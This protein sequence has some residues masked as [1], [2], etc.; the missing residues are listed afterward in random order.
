MKRL[1]ILIL[2][3]VLLVSTPRQVQ[4]QQLVLDAA[5]LAQNVVQALQTILM[6]ANQVLELTPLDEIILSDSF[7]SDLD[8]LGAIIEA[9][10]GLSYDVSSL[11]AQI[12]ALFD[13]TSAPNNS[14]DLQVRLAEIRRVVF[15]SYVYALRT[16][17]LL[18]TTLSAIRHLK[19]LVGAIGDYLGNMQGN[20]SLSQVESTIAETLSRLQVQS[21]AYERAQSVERLTEALTIE[22]I[23]RMNEQLLFDWPR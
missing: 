2:L 17:T 15:D 16:Q 14:R 13:L 9:A 11:Q 18:R 8:D 21:G 20:Q 12:T 10:Q 22:S 6:V 7:D 3:G 5:N 23:H 19:A 1:R 4:A